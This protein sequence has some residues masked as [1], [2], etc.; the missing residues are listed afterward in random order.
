MNNKRI[1]KNA[2][3]LYFR[4]LILMGVM[5]YTSRVLLQQL[6]V[7]D[8]G[9]YNV[10]GGVVAMFSSLR[11]IFAS[12]IQRYLS[13]E[14][15]IKNIDRLREIFSMG[16]MI[17]IVICILFLI[18]AECVGLWLL[19]YKLLISPDRII[20]AHWVF[21]CSIL[22]SI[23]MIMTVPYDA[24]IIANE[25]MAFFAYVSVLDGVLR[26]LIV[27]ALMLSDFDKLKLYAVLVLLVSLVIRGIN[28]IYCKRNFEECVHRAPFNLK[29]F[30]D[31]TGFA[32]WNFMG[33][34]AY[35]LSN[36][37]VNLLLN[38][39]G[40]VAVNAAR[41]IAYQIR[42]AIT[43]VL[44]NIMVAINP[45]AIQLYAQGKRDDFFVM[46]YF[47]SRVISYVYI[48]LAIPLFIHID[49]VLFFW[50]GQIPEYVAIFTKIILVY[51]LIR[52]FH[53]P[54]DLL[55][56]ANGTLKKYQI[57]ELT[58]LILSLPLSYI[59]L[60]MGMPLYSTFIIMLA[61]DILNYFIILFI[62]QKETE[63][64]V[65][66][67]LKKVALTVLIITIVA[68]FGSLALSNVD[69]L[70]FHMF[71]TIIVEMI[72]ISI[73]VFIFG[74]SKTEKKKIMKLV[75]WKYKMNHVL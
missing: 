70:G 66:D 4:M 45:Q 12:A 1:A 51:L 26:L 59:A 47:F 64:I 68:F 60:K 23:I 30:K 3:F 71:F 42:T 50:L 61:L 15:G 57:T 41:G 29:L 62:A 6:G 56:K 55:Y 10:V 11:A 65:A 75:N 72:F 31:M 5:F 54:I 48:I 52:T 63:L 9:V 24:V 20:A 25:R 39:F 2:L 37:G 19:E 32:G 16:V 43:T 18:V 40:G 7:D 34:L 74:F 35:S 49:Y 44:N 21:H 67:Y 58:I 73:I 28:V 53:G 38:M 36:E 27:F 8:F 14:R 22:S 69:R 13:Y 17:H 33:N 46:L